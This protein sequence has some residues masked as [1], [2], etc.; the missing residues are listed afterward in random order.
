MCNTLVAI[1]GKPGATKSF[2][3]MDFTM[4]VATG[5]WW[6][7][8][9]VRQ[10][11]ALYVAA[12][13]SAGLAQRQRAWI[14][15]HGV[16]V[17]DTHLWL[18]HAINMLSRD[19]AQALVDLAAELQPALVVVDTVSRSLPGGDENAAKDMT[20]LVEVSDKTRAACQGTIMLVHH[21]PK[22]G[23]GLRGHSSLEG[24]C[25]TTIEVVKDGTTCTLKNA[26]QKDSAEF[27]DITLQVSVVG[28]SCVLSLP[29]GRGSESSLTQTDETLVAEIGS[30]AGSDGLSGATLRR[31]SSLPERSFYRSLNRLVEAG[32]VL[33][34]GSKTRPFYALAS[35]D[36]LE[37]LPTLPTT[38][39]P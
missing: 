2:L 24:A 39:N 25:D 7:G 29:N 14:T 8:H 16:R 1:Y 28:D 20:T 36:F 6:N 27:P 18:P 3:A 37:L 9:R 10:G 15:H 12:E 19:W 33:K 35:P 4:C 23:G 22:D 34:T 30:V 26:K 32:I 38:A 11:G 21:T 13:G 31:M 17:P 5:K